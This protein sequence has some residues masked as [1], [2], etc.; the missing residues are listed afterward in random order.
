MTLQRFMPDRETVQRSIA[1]LRG[2]SA[3]IEVAMLEIDGVVAVLEQNSRLRR[4][5]RLRNS[6]RESATV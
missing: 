3:K 6:R 5:D 1:K 4:L 2:I